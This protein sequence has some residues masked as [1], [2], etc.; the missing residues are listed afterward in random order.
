MYMDLELEATAHKSRLH[1]DPTT[2]H[3]SAGQGFLGTKALATATMARYPSGA[4]APW[5]LSSLAYQRLG[6]L[7]MMVAADGT[8]GKHT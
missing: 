1:F 5:H 3:T 7:G 4:L 2:L 8:K 6:A